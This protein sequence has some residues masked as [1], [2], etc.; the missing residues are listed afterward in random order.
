[1]VVVEGSHVNRWDLL[2]KVSADV[3]VN[4]GDKYPHHGKS[5]LEPG[6]FCPGGRCLSK[7][8]TDALQHRS[9]CIGIN[10]ARGAGDTIGVVVLIGMSLALNILSLVDPVEDGNGP[11]LRIADYLATKEMMVDDEDGH[12]IMSEDDVIFEGDEKRKEHQLLII[13]SENSTY[14]IFG[15]MRRLPDSCYT[16]PP[17]SHFPHWSS[18]P[19]LQSHYY[20]ILSP[21]P[22]SPPLHVSSLPPASPIRQLGYRAAMIR[23]IGGYVLLLP[24]TGRYAGSREMSVMGSPILGNGDVVGHAGEPATDAKSLGQ[25]M[26]RRLRTGC[27]LRGLEV[28]SN[29]SSDLARSEVMALRTQVVAQQANSEYRVNGADNMRLVAIKEM[30]QADHMRRIHGPAKGPAQPDAPEEAGSSS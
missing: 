16:T 10:K 30:L 21:L 7:T 27:L 8:R 6:D 13:G 19:Q 23:L 5:G 25:G 26:D 18:P 28:R 4:R 11:L 2:A 12:S 15:L 3:A 24:W 29:G 1:M 9:I 22:V 17:P 14:T 20:L